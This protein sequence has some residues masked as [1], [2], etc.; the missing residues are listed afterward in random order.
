MAPIKCNVTG[1]GVPIMLNNF[2]CKSTELALKEKCP[3][4]LKHC[5]YTQSWLTW[6]VD[7]LFKTLLKIC[8]ILN[9]A[10]VYLNFFWPRK[11]SKTH[12]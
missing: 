11:L 9:H 12:F 6:T 1:K 3:S 5:L 10:E 7:Q 4:N 8:I 2:L